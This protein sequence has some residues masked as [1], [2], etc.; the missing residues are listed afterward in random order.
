[1]AYK[2]LTPRLYTKGLRS[3]SGKDKDLEAVLIKFGPPPLWIREPGFLTLIHI[4]LEQQVSLAS[5]KA[6]YEKLIRS[7]PLLTAEI[8]LKI[9]DKQLKQIG[10]SRQKMRYGRHL[11]QAIL[12]KQLDLDCLHDGSD[13]E[14][15]EALQKIT[16]IGRWTADIYLLMALK[17][18][19]IWPTGDLALIS[20]LQHVKNLNRKPTAEEFTKFGEAWKPWR[21]VAARILWHH[22][23]SN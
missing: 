9:N 20:A 21:A 12:D 22:Y 16:G 6:A 18:P 5:A 19:D 8:F 4:I 23:L 7:K 14:V 3:L 10:F 13:D 17:R 11:A 2:L 15:R 1:V